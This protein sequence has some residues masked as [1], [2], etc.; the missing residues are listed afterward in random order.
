MIKI[1][2]LT[3]GPIQTNAY[4]LSNPETGK[5]II[6]DPGM[7][8][9]PLIKRIANLDIE[10]ILLTHAHFDHIGG[11]EE[12]RKLKKCPVYIHDLEADWLTNPKKNGSARWPDLG[13]PIIAEPAEY[14]LDEGQVLEFLGIKLKVYHTPGHSPGSVSFMYDNHL[15]GGD[16]LFRMSVGR[17]DLPGG[18]SNTLL[19]SI[20][21]KL[22]ELDDEVIVYP[23]HGPKTTIGYERDNNPYV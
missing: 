1:E 8:P 18:D 17:T 12:I 7:N 9:G 14:A 15:F 20:Q 23:G 19:D 22:F 11:V 4:L 6:I 21:G 13:A 2:A 5:G 3:L 10:A 16:V